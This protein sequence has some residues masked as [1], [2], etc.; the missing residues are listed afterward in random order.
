MHPI[1]IIEYD[2]LKNYFM[3]FSIM[4]FFHTVFLIV[5][6]IGFYL[7]IKNVVE[8]VAGGDATR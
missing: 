2:V 1:G 7:K 3:Y 4:E 8:Q 5:G 6:I